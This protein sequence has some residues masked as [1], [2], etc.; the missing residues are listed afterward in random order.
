MSDDQIVCCPLDGGDE[1]PSCSTTK[2]VTARKPYTCCEC[3][4]PIPQ[5]QKY[6][7]FTGIWDGSPSMYRT[8]LSCAEI[9]NHFACKNG[10]TFEMLW[11]QLE[12][13]FFPDMKA[14]GPCM[15]GLS[16][17]A[18]ARLFERRLKWLERFEDR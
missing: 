17:E 2:I 13:Y 10:W 6:E 14:G 7:Y 3:H 16:P 8:C 4:E 5:N 11:E 9:R 1:G 15:K 18:K 12:E